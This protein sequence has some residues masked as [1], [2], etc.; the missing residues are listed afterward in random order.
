M[1]NFR[2]KEERKRGSEGKRILLK[3]TK[4][5]EREKPRK[6]AELKGRKEIVPKKGEKNL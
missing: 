3:F 1:N 6:F 2:E 5:K 4:M